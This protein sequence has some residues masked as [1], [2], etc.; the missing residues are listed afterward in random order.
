MLLKIKLIPPIFKINVRVVE[1]PVTGKGAS[2]KRT[3]KEK[4]SVA[5]LPF[6]TG[7]VELNKKKWRRSFKTTL[8][9][10]AA[11]QDD[12]FGTNAI[13]DNEV[14]VIWKL[15]FPSLLFDDDDERWE[16]ILHVVCL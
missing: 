15:V 12:P 2:G 13:M 6:P 7:T 16:P 5:S 4:Y 10:W 1:T 8:I 11:T 3:R 9:H 14:K